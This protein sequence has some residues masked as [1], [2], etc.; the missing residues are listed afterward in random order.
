MTKTGKQKQQLLRIVFVGIVFCLLFLGNGLW[1]A[2]EQ[3]TNMPAQTAPSSQSAREES[4][5]ISPDQ[6]DSSLVAAA[7]PSEGEPTQATRL[8]D[9]SEALTV[10]SSRSQPSVHRSQRDHQAPQD[11]LAQ[12]EHLDHRQRFLR[13][14]AFARTYD[15]FIETRPDPLIDEDPRMAREEENKLLTDDE[16]HPSVDEAYDPLTDEDPHPLTDEA[17]DPLTAEGLPS[18]TAEG[19]NPFTD[20]E[21]S[22]VAG[23]VER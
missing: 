9:L 10:L 1:P 15:P 5:R 12:R 14:Q 21:P 8:S 16:P 19:P 17:Y 2:E 7:P 13:A 20:N 6:D 23:L 18:L 4:P 11:R 22:R 3:V